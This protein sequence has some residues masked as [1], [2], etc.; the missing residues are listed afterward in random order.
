MSKEVQTE[1]FHT[2]G[3]GA[4]PPW[5]ASEQLCGKYEPNTHE[6]PALPTTVPV[7]RPIQDD[8]VMDEQQLV[9]D[10]NWNFD[11]AHPQSIG[12]HD[13]E[14]RQGTTDVCDLRLVGQSSRLLRPFLAEKKLTCQPD[15]T[16][17]HGFRSQQANIASGLQQTVCARPAKL[18]WISLPPM[19]TDSGCKTG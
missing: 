4:H 6:A 1:P 13:N 16:P 7:T 18:L 9:P 2:D 17:A 10:S 3:S 8:S 14:S 11:D 12:S 19:G 5:P 15:I